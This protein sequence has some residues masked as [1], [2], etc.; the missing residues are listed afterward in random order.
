[1]KSYSSKI[2][3][4][5]SR[6][7]VEKMNEIVIKMKQENPENEVIQSDLC[8]KDLDEYQLS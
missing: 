2:R 1:M 4:G 7:N 8:F 6:L 3:K 5:L